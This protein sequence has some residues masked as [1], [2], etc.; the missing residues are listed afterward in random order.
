MIIQE[1][2]FLAESPL[3]GDLSDAERRASLSPSDTTMNDLWGENGLSSE[4]PLEECMIL[5]GKVFEERGS[6]AYVWLSRR[7]GSAYF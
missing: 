1:A 6:Q 4:E 5:R 7:G 2:A 3:F